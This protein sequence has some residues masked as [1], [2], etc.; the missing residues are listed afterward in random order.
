MYIHRDFQPKKVLETIQNEQ[1]N[2]MFLAPSMW[3]LLVQAADVTT[4]NV[5]SMEYCIL[6]SAI[7]P[8]ELKRKIMRVFDNASIFEAFGQ[9]EM[10]PSTT[11]LLPE[12]SLRKTE[13]VGKPSVNVRVRIVDD[14]M[15]DVPIGEVGEII[16]Q[17][18]TVMKEYYK[19][20]EATAEAFHGGWFHSGDLVRMDEEGFI[21]VVDRKKDMIISGG[22]NIY[23]AE[24][25][26]VLYNHPDILEAAVIGVPNAEWGE[27]VK[28]YVALKPGTNLNADQIIV[29]CQNHL[30][31]YKKPSIVEFVDSLPRNAAG[32]VLKQALRK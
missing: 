7:S 20:P 1:I 9:T 29:H 14:E 32:K 26:E 12:D 27:S 19:N 18:P 6:G 11:Y 24:V 31:S 23:S 4:F 2:S 8:V 21:Y 25:E 10:S 22:E 13:S 5:S 3:N 15:K 28:A 16:Y 30:A 17:G